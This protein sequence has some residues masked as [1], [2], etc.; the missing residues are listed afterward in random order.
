MYFQLY[1]FLSRCKQ[2]RLIG[3]F[4]EKQEIFA[5]TG[6]SRAGFSHRPEEHSK[7]TAIHALSVGIGC[8]AA[9]DGL[10]G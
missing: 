8:L 1:L 4:G 2:T 9:S 3:H 5:K 10:E 7:Y 6:H